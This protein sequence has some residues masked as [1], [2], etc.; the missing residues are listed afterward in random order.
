MNTSF[1]T[2]I[3]KSIDLSG[4]EAKILRDLSLRENGSMSLYLTRERKWGNSKA[5]VIMVFD[6]EKLIGWAH[7]IPGTKRSSVCHFYVRK[8][9]R[10]MGIGTHLMNT[11]L[12]NSTQAR[13]G[14]CSHS[15]ES[16]RFFKRFY[17]RKRIAE[18]GWY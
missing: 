13:V 9:H 12:K 8:T 2:E 1:R 10:R 3:R 17:K 16:Y 15:A 6:G 11:A 7:F 4:A 18:I 5:F 14:V